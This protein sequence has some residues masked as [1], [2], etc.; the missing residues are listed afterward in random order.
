MKKYYLELKV[1]QEIY[2]A[3][4][5]NL[6]ISSLGEERSNLLCY[7]DKENHNQQVNVIR[8]QTLFQNREE[9][10]KSQTL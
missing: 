5:L 9:C 10:S 8:T 7:L 2:M 4:V 6:V 1:H 3:T